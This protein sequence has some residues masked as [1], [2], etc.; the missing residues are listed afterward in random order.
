[1]EELSRYPRHYVLP[2]AANFLIFLGILLFLRVTKL[3]WLLLFLGDCLFV[4]YGVFLLMV[5]TQPGTK[6]S[7]LVGMSIYFLLL[8]ALCRKTIFE[9]FAYRDLRF[10]ERAERFSSNQAVWISFCGRESQGGLTDV[11]FTGCS[12]VSEI[13][14]PLAEIVD[15]R[16]SAQAQTAFLAQVLRKEVLADKLAY[17]LKFKKR[18]TLSQLRS[19]Q[20][21]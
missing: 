5:G 1:M 14:I 19:L 3:G 8:V 6:V 9:L 11:S 17:G 13:E 18:L 15:L 16:P 7:L 2:V 21:G 20:G 4:L 12:M 10:W